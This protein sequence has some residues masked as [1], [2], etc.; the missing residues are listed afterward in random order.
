[1]ELLGALGC[2]L[3]GMVK[4]CRFCYV[5]LSYVELVLV[6][7]W[8]VWCVFFKS[9]LVQLRLVLAGEVL[10]CE[11]F[12]GHVSSVKAGVACCEA[13]GNAKVCCGMAGKLSCDHARRIFDG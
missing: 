2:A 4:P 1:M 7:A 11:S 3:A 9:R 6:C 13:L 10:Y 8:Q 5:P 12:Y